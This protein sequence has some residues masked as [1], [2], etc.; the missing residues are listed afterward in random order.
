MRAC[1]RVY[2]PPPPQTSTAVLTNDVGFYKQWKP[3]Q[4]PSPKPWRLLTDPVDRAVADIHLPVI[5]PSSD[6]D[7]SAGLRQGGPGVGGLGGG[8]VPS[9]VGDGEGG[10]RKT[11]GRRNGRRVQGEAQA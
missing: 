9:V 6:D 3:W 7:V 2:V 4:R 1:V 10:V 8:R 5:L 11:E